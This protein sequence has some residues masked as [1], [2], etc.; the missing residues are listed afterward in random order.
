MNYFICSEIW[1]GCR[2]GEGHASTVY[3]ICRKL[4][5]K[6]PYPQKAENED[7]RRAFL[8]LGARDWVVLDIND[9][10]LEGVWRDSRK[11]RVFYLNWARG[12]PDNGGKRRNQDYVFM[13]ISTGKWEDWGN[14]REWII[15]EK[16]PQI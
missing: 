1:S 9:V 14:D 11:N 10:A 15:C 2:T 13:R 16:E 8:S 4:G 12:Q 3:E 5:A 6:V 7:Y